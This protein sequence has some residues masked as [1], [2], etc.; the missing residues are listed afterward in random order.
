VNEREEIGW[1]EAERNGFPRDRAVDDSTPSG[2]AVSRQ[3]PAHGRIEPSSGRKCPS[4]QIL[5]GSSALGLD[6]PLSAEGLSIP[7][8]CPHA[9]QV[10]GHRIIRRLGRGGQGHVWQAVRLTDNENVAIKIID[11]EQ[12]DSPQA[13]ARFEQG[14]RTLA[15]LSHPN[16]VK[17]LDHGLLPGGESWHAMEY[18]HG[19]SLTEYVDRLDAEEL[20][21]KSAKRRVRF[22]LRAAL[23]LFVKVCQ[24]VEAAHR[25]G[26]IH[27]DL[28]PSNILVDG[29]GEPRLLDFGLARLPQ[30]PSATLVT[31]T[32]QFL[33]SPAWASPEQVEGHPDRIDIRSDVYSLGI[34][35]YQS[36]TGMFPY[37]VDGPLARTFDQILHADPAP[38]RN[39][40]SFITPDLQAVMLKAIAKQ[41]E[42]RYQ[43]VGELRGDI[44]RFLRGEVVLAKA[45]SVAYVA[46]KFVQR[47]RAFTAT[48]ALAVLLTAIYAVTMTLA[49][50]RTSRAEAQAREAADAATRRFELARDTAQFLLDEVDERLKDVAGAGRLRRVLLEKS[51]D[52]FQSLLAE[53]SDDL[54]AQRELARWTI[55]LSDIAA[56]L[57]RL[58]EADVKRREALEI[59]QRLAA[60]D[61]EDEELQEALSINLV[62]VGDIARGRGDW[63]TTRWYYEQALQID[64]QLVARCPE[65]PRFADNLGY[66]YQRVAIV[67]TTKEADESVRLDLLLRRQRLAERLVAEQPDNLVRRYGLVTSNRDLAEHYMMWRNDRERAGTYLQAEYEL[68]RQVMQADPTS[69]PFR[70][71]W[72]LALGRRADYE[73]CAGHFE[74]ASQFDDQA[75][76]ELESL[77]A[78]EP[79]RITFMEVLLSVRQNQALSAAFSR[80][81][82][83]AAGH[84]ETLLAELEELVSVEEPKSKNYHGLIGNAAGIEIAVLAM[85]AMPGEMDAVESSITQT[86]SWSRLD[87]IWKWLDRRRPL[88]KTMAAS[89][90]RTPPGIPADA[91]ARMLAIMDRCL[92]AIPIDD[93]PSSWWAETRANVEDLREI[94]GIP[95]PGTDP[96]PTEPVA[97]ATVGTG[98]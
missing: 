40:A 93:K 18:V 25:V 70:F 88:L 5:T 98:G 61:P 47:H 20:D 29:K 60:A 73:W 54:M 66:S 62:L 8:E 81:W 1:P 74:L 63:A 75:A 38:P 7:S 14:Y 11:R 37:D 83:G 19:C 87:L 58:D 69:A 51:Y 12:L 28:K 91:A 9:P 90:P 72:A 49:Y 2:D 76:A 3:D 48:A 23:G 50:H 71:V 57:G 92:A 45:D 26:I 55:K 78:A 64:E 24:A 82:S 80:N 96:R 77:H 94:Y 84:L 39:H 56:E 34:V 21:R 43:S 22:P 15:L 10:P 31:L 36:L 97:K 46:W 79:G 42:R 65:N 30:A 6:G 89:Q 52:R 53:R 86:G 44:E 95:A 4:A 41:R 17:G 85:N 35:L 32:G 27:R 13:R 16:I 68:A 33:G 67:L 59:H